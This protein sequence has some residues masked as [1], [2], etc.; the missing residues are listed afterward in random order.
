MDGVTVQPLQSVQLELPA[1]ALAFA[2]MVDGGYVVLCEGL[3]PETVLL[4]RFAVPAPHAVAASRQPCGMV[5]LA[6]TADGARV[7][8]HPRLMQAW[9]LCGEPSGGGASLYGIDGLT[10][11][12][13]F[14]LALDTHP[15]A[16]LRAG[17]RLIFVDPNDVLNV[18]D[19]DGHD[20]WQHTAPAAITA[21]AEHPDGGVLYASADGEVVW[22]GRDGEAVAGQAIGAALRAV[23]VS[24]RGRIAGHDGERL[25][26]WIGALAPEHVGRRIG[27]MAGAPSVDARDAIFVRH[28]EQGVWRISPRARAALHWAEGLDCSAPRLDYSGA[29]VVTASA[30]GENALLAWPPSPAGQRRPGAA[31]AFPLPS[32]PVGLGFDPYCVTVLCAGGELVDRRLLI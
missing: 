22:L 11:A 13:R 24:D 4:C 21:L 14:R 9:V 3:Q 25:W 5:Q 27:P 31:T 8:A 32:A 23:S 19:A 7:L 10:H 12:P 1:R 26:T 18:V 16:L 2:P 6:G 15:T 28:A 30:E 29:T 17:D 20:L